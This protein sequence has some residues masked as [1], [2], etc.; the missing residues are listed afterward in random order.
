MNYAEISLNV[1]SLKFE[2]SEKILYG[3]CILDNS[4]F[5]LKKL[6]DWQKEFLRK[7]LFKSILRAYKPLGWIEQD[8]ILFDCLGI[9]KDDLRRIS[10]KGFLDKVIAELTER[11]H[12]NKTERQKKIHIAKMTRLAIKYLNE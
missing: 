10:D 4:Y 5:K 1:I 9:G 7:V 6:T 11:T 3:V 2:K 12:E 8:I